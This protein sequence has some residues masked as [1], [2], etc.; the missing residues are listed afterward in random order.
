MRRSPGRRWIIV[1]LALVLILTGAA[2]VF[3]PRASRVTRENF[4]RLHGRMT[5]TE[6]EAILGPPGDYRT[7][8]TGAISA[9]RWDYLHV[10]EEAESPLA[11]AAG[12]V[13]EWQSDSVVIRVAYGRSDAAAEASCWDHERQERGLLDNLLWRAGHLWRRWFP[14]E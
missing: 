9:P 14:E 1:S 8:P 2:F 13:D 7:G 12:A 11:E 10:F 4:Q 6:V 5:R 3:W